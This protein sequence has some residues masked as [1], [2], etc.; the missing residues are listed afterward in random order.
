VPTMMRSQYLCYLSQTL[1]FQRQS[2]QSGPPSLSSLTMSKTPAVAQGSKDV[3]YRRQVFSLR[4]SLAGQRLSG[5]PEPLGPVR[6]LQ[7]PVLCLPGAVHTEPFVC[8]PSSPLQLV[9]HLL[10]W[11]MIAGWC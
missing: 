1:Q 7:F 10:G 3:R 11:A 6:H 9:M 8:L 5:R 4:K 2:I